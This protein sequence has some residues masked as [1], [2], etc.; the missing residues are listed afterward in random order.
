MTPAFN[1][2]IRPSN[3]WWQPLLQCGAESVRQRTVTQDA[4]H[5]VWSRFVARPS[6]PRPAWAKSAD[7]HIVEPPVARLFNAY[8]IVDW[9]AASKPGTGTDLIRI[10]VMKRDVRFR[11]AFE[12]YALA[13]RAEAE[14]RLNLILDD[15]KKR[16]ERAFLGFNFPLGFPHGLAEALTL[17]G[18]PWAGVWD[19]IDRQVK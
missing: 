2:P 10:G 14:K 6:R 11:L 16:S 4:Q 1:T 12:S 7:P 18:E 3:S 19:F 8:V 9:S 15:L 13:T 5:H 17:N